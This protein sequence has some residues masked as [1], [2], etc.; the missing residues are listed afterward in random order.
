MPAI[1]IDGDLV[2]KSHPSGRKLRDALN[3]R[4]QAQTA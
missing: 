4:L 3:E 2:F 1:A